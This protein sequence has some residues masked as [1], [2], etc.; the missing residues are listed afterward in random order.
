MSYRPGAVVAVC[1]C[2]VPQATQAVTEKDAFRHTHTRKD[3]TQWLKPPLHSLLF[4]LAVLYKRYKCRI[5]GGEG[6]Y[7]PKSCSGGSHRGESISV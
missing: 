7:H 3:Y 6:G 2:V 1:V 5:G 4:H